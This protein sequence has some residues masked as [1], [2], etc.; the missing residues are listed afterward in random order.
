M[1]DVFSPI[2]KRP[3][4]MGRWTTP[5]STRARFP[6]PLSKNPSTLNGLGIG[7]S[8]CNEHFSE[9]T[10]YSSAPE[11]MRLA[12]SGMQSLESLVWLL[13]SPC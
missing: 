10:H 5:C 6:H 13:P 9:K 8:V 4:K 3:S 1:Q 7:Q 12:H 2:D 11:F